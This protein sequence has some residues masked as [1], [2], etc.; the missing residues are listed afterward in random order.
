MLWTRGQS[1]C[2][3]LLFS[4]VLLTR[5]ATAVDS[6]PRS[7]LTRFLLFNFKR[8]SFNFQAIADFPAGAIL[9]L[10]CGDEHERSVNSS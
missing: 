7:S 5:G 8:E 4:W 1:E 2:L 9:I 10:R 6:H 3:I